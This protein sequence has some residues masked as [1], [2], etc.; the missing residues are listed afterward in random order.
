MCITVRVF[1]GHE[2]EECAKCRWLAC[3]KLHLQKCY[4]HCYNNIEMRV[5]LDSPVN[6]KNMK[7]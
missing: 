3:A 7:G 2:L 4:K 5:S 1:T 6:V